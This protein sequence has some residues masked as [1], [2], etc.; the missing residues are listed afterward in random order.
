MR[1]TVAVELLMHV[2]FGIK[3]RVSFGAVGDLIVEKCVQRKMF[4]DGNAD[5]HNPLKIS[6]AVSGW[7]ELVYNKMVECLDSLWIPLL[8]PIVQYSLSPPQ[9]L[10]AII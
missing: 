10:R 6:M 2:M 5:F 3:M 4:S 8:L 7:L 9:I 1:A